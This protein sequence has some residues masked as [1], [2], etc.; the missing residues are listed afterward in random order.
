MSADS[1]RRYYL[2]CHIFFFPRYTRLKKKQTNVGEC[3]AEDVGAF[4]ANGVYC[5]SVPSV[6]EQVMVRGGDVTRY[7]DEARR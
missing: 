5:A 2:F 6:N 4:F 3:F 1:S 7:H